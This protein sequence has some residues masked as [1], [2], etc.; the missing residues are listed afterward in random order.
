MNNTNT[1]MNKNAVRKVENN[2]YT[3]ELVLGAYPLNSK[4]VDVLKELYPQ[5]SNF[6]D[7]L[8]SVLTDGGITI[9]ACLVAHFT[10]LKDQLDQGLYSIYAREGFKAVEMKFSFIGQT[11][12]NTLVRYE[13]AEQQILRRAFLTFNM[14]SANRKAVQAY[15]ANYGL[16]FATMGDCGC[17]IVPTEQLEALEVDALYNANNI[18][19]SGFNAFAIETFLVQPENLSNV[20]I[21]DFHKASDLPL[22]QSVRSAIAQLAKVDEQS[23]RPADCSEEFHNAMDFIKQSYRI[24]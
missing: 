7:G 17:C 12:N 16:Q 6:I 13:T 20:V 3:E 24:N 14:R 22:L 23:G 2:F 9:Q 4:H 8:V 5:Q 11:E 19:R 18:A 1:S 10:A 21:S 15:M